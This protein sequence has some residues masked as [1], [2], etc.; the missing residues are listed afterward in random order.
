MPKQPIDV[1]LSLF[2]GGLNERL[3]PTLLKP[4]EA[5]VALDVAYDT[6]HLSGLTGPG[7]SGY[8]S[9]ATSGSTFLHFTGSEWLSSAANRYALYDGTNLYLTQ[10][11]SYP[12]I[13]GTT[14]VRLGLAAPATASGALTAAGGGIS[15]Y[16]RYAVTYV[17]ADGIESNPTFTAILWSGVDSKAVITYATITDARVT[18][19]KLYRTLV[20]SVTRVGTADDAAGALYYVGDDSDLLDNTIEDTGA[21]NGTAA[22]A[23]G[24]GGFSTSSGYT[25]DHSPAPNL[26]MLSTGIHSTTQTNGAS[27]LLLGVDTSGNLRWNLFGRP[28]YWPTNNSF[29]PSETPEALVTHAAQSVLVTSAAIYV[30]SGLTDE[31]L[32]VSRSNSN[33]GC[34]PG[35]GRAVVYTPY[36]LV[37]PSIRGIE[38]FDGSNSQV[39]T[40]GKLLPSTFQGYAIRSAVFWGGQYILFHDDGTL[41]CDLRNLPEVILTTSDLVVSAAQVAYAVIA[42]VPAGTCDPNAPALT[43]TYASLATPMFGVYGTAI[44]GNATKILAVGGKTTAQGAYHSSAALYD[45][46]SGLWTPTTDLPV[47]LGDTGELSP[48]TLLSIS[49]QEF[50]LIGH[51]YAYTYNIAAETW[52]PKTGLSGAHV[53]NRFAAVY[54]GAD[55]VYVV[56]G[57][58]LVGGVGV[59]SAAGTAVLMKYSLSGD[60]WT[61]GPA[62]DDD[63]KC[64]NVGAALHNGSLYVAGWVADPF[65]GYAHK[66]VKRD[67]SNFAT[68]GWT[69]IGG[70]DP[71][72]FGSTVAAT[73]EGVYLTQNGTRMARVDLTDDSAAVMAGWSTL[74]FTEPRIFRAGTCDLYVL[75]FEAAAATAVFLRLT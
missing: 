34:L 26:T 58:L 10:S 7:S 11:G 64:A 69:V 70:I 31:D 60:S 3:A 9:P 13:H 48:A 43:G 15:G 41:I 46:A 32:V 4:T 37:F 30:I 53:R 72:N 21:P 62:G 29:R 2:V 44:A 17:T 68:G 27:G 5:Q 23:H 73:G 56:G 42:P 50:L 6:G 14:P 66:V 75:G 25:S 38:L 36:G 8:L 16:R 63:Y 39:F 52:T 40:S 49:E 74:S 28:H 12:V 45:I 67:L 22:L 1:A 24:P 47:A 57:L 18:R 20:D 19:V 35:A 61:V 71:T 65:Y 33:V 59:S 55:S 54:D 51:N